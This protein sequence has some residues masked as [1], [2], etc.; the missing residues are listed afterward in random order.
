MLPQNLSTLMPGNAQMNYENKMPVLAQELGLKYQEAT[1]EGNDGK[2]IMNTG[3]EMYGEYRHHK[4]EIAM[5]VTAKHI[6]LSIGSYSYSM[7]KLIAFEVANPDG[8][9]FHIQPKSKNII[10]KDTGE[11]NFDEKL[12]LSGNTE[13]PN[14]YLN[15]FGNLGWLNLKLENNHLVFNDTFYEDLMQS[16][17]VSTM[18]IARH[19]IWESTP[20]NPEISVDKVKEF[21]DKIIDLSESLKLN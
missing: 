5:G 14:E 4:M 17:G 2:T 1:N 13:I 12:M 16:E 19:P 8:K 3:C 21:I 18:M 7:K 6:G 9:S 20:Q 15:Y 10:A 11:R